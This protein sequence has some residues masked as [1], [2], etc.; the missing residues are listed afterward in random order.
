MKIIKVSEDESY[1][2]GHQ[3]PD[4]DHG[5]PLHDMTILYPDDIYSANG[6]RYYGDSRPDDNLAMSIIH[7]CRN[8]P[9][10]AVKIYRAVPA[11][12]NSRDRLKRIYE[13]QAQILRRGRMPSN[14]L[15]EYKGVDNT[16][17][18]YDF[19]VSEEKKLEGLVDESK[20]KI[21]DGNWVTTVRAYARD[22]GEAWLKNDFRI[23]EKTVPA[24]SLWTEGNSIF[25]FGYLP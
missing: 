4:R 23:L 20:V 6:A 8:K 12:I 3:P 1:R 25:E 11:L 21:E 10:K 14:L 2:G 5:A 19:L 17:R 16:S 22:H 15:P 13:Q 9:N 18:Y 24:S 7:S